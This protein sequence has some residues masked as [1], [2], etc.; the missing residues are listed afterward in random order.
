MA[1]ANHRQ[2]HQN[3]PDDGEHDEEGQDHAHRHRP[4]EVQRGGGHV[5]RTVGGGVGAHRPRRGAVGPQA[6]PGGGGQPGWECALL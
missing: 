2:Y 1:V 5:L 4:T 6:H 3:V